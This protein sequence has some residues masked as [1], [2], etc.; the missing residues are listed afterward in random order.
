M[1]K[2]DQIIE[3]QTTIT[4][5]HTNFSENIVNTGKSF[6]K[7]FKDMLPMTNNTE[8]LDV[9]NSLNDHDFYQYVV[10]SF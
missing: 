5:N 3:S 6:S 4:M 9:E 2:L 7:K 1:L 8:I 10:R